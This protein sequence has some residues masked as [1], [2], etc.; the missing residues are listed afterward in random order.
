MAAACGDLLI[1]LAVL[2]LVQ[3]LASNVAALPMW[4][5]LLFVITDVALRSWLIRRRRNGVSMQVQ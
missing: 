2:S 3:L 1:F 5:L 4:P